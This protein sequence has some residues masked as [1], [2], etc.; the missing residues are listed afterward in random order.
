MT[1]RRQVQ[2]CVTKVK[3]TIEATSQ[4]DAHSVTADGTI[5]EA[6]TVN[7]APGLYFKG[8]RNWPCLHRDGSHSLL[9]QDDKLDKLYLY[10]HYE[11]SCPHYV[12]TL[13]IHEAAFVA[14]AGGSAKKFHK[15]Y[16]NRL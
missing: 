14:A 15:Q 9:W 4:R 7:Q 2:E 3:W 8:G 12:R 5:G 13:N 6:A 1:R 10:A 16:Y 11:R